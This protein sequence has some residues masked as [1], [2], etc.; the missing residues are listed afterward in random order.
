MRL[1]GTDQLL[2]GSQISPRG[3]RFESELTH[4]D[5]PE[6][7]TFVFAFETDTEFTDTLIIVN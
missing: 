7:A 5:L 6:V 2:S 1:C 3:R 4:P